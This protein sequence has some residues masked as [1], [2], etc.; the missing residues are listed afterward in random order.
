MTFYHAFN[1]RGG[2]PGC[3]GGEHTGTVEQGVRG[4]FNGRSKSRDTDPDK[5]IIVDTMKLLGNSA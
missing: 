4:E 1:V 5:A 2:S 3:G